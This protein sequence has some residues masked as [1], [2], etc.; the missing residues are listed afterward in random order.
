M[1]LNRSLARR[2]ALVAATAA[3]ALALA[4]CGGSGGSTSGHDMSSMNSGSPSASA[5]AST[6]AHNAQDVEFAQQMITHHRQ[7]VEMAALAATRASSGEV[8]TLAAKIKGA[9]DP[10][11]TTMSGWLT[12]WGESVPEDMTG[13]GHDM[14]SDMPG[15][16]SSD[17]MAKLG[18]ASG[19]EFGTMFMEMMTEHHQGA[20]E[21][22]RTEQSKGEYGPAR[23]LAASVVTAQTA[24]IRQMNGLL[25]NA[26]AA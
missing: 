25:T 17:D 4:A 12:S 13:M 6:G 16:M 23:T 3:A 14:S 11:I 9:Q 19:A 2:S 21:M 22:A 15:M 10:E 5:S 24:E 8:K 20:I 18:K 1:T 26:A 7:A